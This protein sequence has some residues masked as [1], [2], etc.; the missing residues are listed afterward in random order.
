MAETVRIVDGQFDFSGGVDSGKVT[1]IKSNFSPNGIERNQVAWA[2]NV[3]M[4]GGGI[5]QRTGWITHPRLSD[6]S[7]L[8]QGGYVYEPDG[9]N[10]YL[11]C[12][13]GGRILKMLLEEPYTVTDLSAIFGL[14]NPATVEQA[15]FVQGEQ[16][17]IIQAGDF[18]S[19]GAVVPGTTDTVGRT[20]PL[21]W[22]GTT[23]RRSLGIT[24]T[25]PAGI[26]PNINEIP[27]A[28]AMDYFQGRIWYA[29]GRN[30]S[31]GDIVGGPS[32]TL[33]NRFRDSILSVTENPLCFGGDGFTVPTNAGNIRALAHTANIDTTLGQGDL[34]IFTRKV[35]YRLQVPVTRTAWIAATANNQPVQTV[36]QRTNGTY[37]DRCIVAVNGDLFYQSTDGIR[38]LF[39]AR[40]DFQT[41]GNIPISNNLERL[42]QFN[43]RALMRFSSGIEFDNRLWQTALPIQTAA[44]VAFQAVVTL[45]FDLISTLQKKL[46]PAWEGMLEGQNFLQLFSGD[47]GGFERAFGLNVSKI[48]GSVNL[49]EFTKSDRT[50]DQDKD[51]ETE[52]GDRRV[53]WFFETPSY[54]WGQD[55]MLKELDGLE[56]WI[57][58]LFCSLDYTVEYRV[59]ADP[60]WQMWHRGQICVARSTCEDVNNP[61]CYPEQEY[62]EGYKLP[63]TLPKPPYPACA[64]MQNRPVNI[65][66]Q[67]QVRITFKGWARVRAILIYALPIKRAP[68]NGLAC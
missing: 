24:T 68:F 63:I 37:G 2:T 65:G 23:L 31:A 26:L 38:S 16:Y 4:R 10:P 9:A 21:F 30:Y 27:A 52:N 40:R 8:F 60:C 18:Y 49:I 15:Y 7:S 57:D 59:D 36:A 22:D 28:T 6:G 32:G 45:D 39:V 61:V 41:W 53:V 34:Y 20:L 13:V 48:D 58:K 11:V 47:F 33:A 5:R 64:T 17:L 42:L 1:T 62:R 14:T 46:P 3:T 12:S 54:T 56:I 51:P 19:P 35:V 29:Q 44:G 25:T 43:D 67:F 66:F 55:F 50:D